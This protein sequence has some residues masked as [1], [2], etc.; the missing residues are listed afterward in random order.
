MRFSGKRIQLLNNKNTQEEFIAAY[1]DPYLL[2]SNSNY[3]DW[4]RYDSLE[5]SFVSGSDHISY[6]YNL[7]EGRQKTWTNDVYWKIKIRW[8]K[9]D[10]INTWGLTVSFV[11]YQLWCQFGA[12]NTAYVKVSVNDDS[13][14]YCFK[15]SSQLWRLISIKCDEMDY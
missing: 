9:V 15:I 7:S 14:F 1:T 3:I 2:V 10:S 6:A 12:W 11:P 4:E 13:D 8:L 5:I